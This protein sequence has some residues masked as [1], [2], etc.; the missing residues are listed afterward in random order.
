MAEIGDAILGLGDPG[1]RRLR[2]RRDRDRGDRLGDA[3][4]SSVAACPR[5]GGGRSAR[6]RVRRSCASTTPWT[7]SN[8]RSASRARS[9]AA[10][11][12][13]R[14]VVR[15]LTAQHVRDASFE[16][17]RAIVR[18]GMRRRTRSARR[19]RAHPAAVP[20]RRSRRS[21][22]PA[23]STPSGCARTCR[24]PIRSRPRRQRLDAL[25]ASM[26]D[27]AALVS[28]LSSRFAEDEWRDASRAA[29]RRRRRGR[30]GRALTS[31]RPPQQRERPDAHR[32]RRPGHRRAVAAPR[33][34][35]RAHPGRDATASSRRPRRRC[36][37]SSRRRARRCGRRWRR[38]S[39][40]TPPTPTGSARSCARSRRELTALE[41]DAARRPDPH[42]RP[43]RAPA[44]PARSR[45]RRCAHRA[46]AAARRAHRAARHPGRRAQR[47]RARRGVGGAHA[48]QRRRARRGSSRRSA[49]SPP[50]ARRRTRWRRWMPRAARCATPRT[51]RR[52]P[53]TTGSAATD[54]G[55]PAEV[56]PLS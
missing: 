40:S 39:S 7:S 18:A 22:R 47:D 43:H 5:R 32:A 3:A 35:R 52:S 30:G 17:Y 49:S 16:D 53:T 20:P 28:E 13:P 42:D 23:P 55:P 4:G 41:T 31:R 44:R 21:P 37:A 34:G 12:P 46:A 15:A 1:A 9:T 48:R 24:P 11:R 14:C 36:P 29:R 56:A 6:A 26:G 45:A 8:S 2:R 19:R 27:P 10:D 50:R 54:G 33:R 25:R 51:P 38:A